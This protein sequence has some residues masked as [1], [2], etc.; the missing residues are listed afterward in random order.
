MK[1]FLILALLFTFN[2]TSGIFSLECPKNLTVSFV[3][4]KENEAV[5][6]AKQKVTLSI[7]QKDG[8]FYHLIQSN[9]NDKKKINYLQGSGAINN[10]NINSNVWLGNDSQGKNSSFVITAIVSTKLIPKEGKVVE[11]N[12]SALK[13]T[14][15]CNKTSITVNRAN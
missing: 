5:N 9:A 14:E 1:Q 6:G 10:L 8:L 12:D 7:S 13:P 4:P 2:F 15:I 3:S 11:W